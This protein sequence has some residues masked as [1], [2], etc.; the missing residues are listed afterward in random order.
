M[1]LNVWYDGYK[2]TI[3]ELNA[4][5]TEGLWISLSLESDEEMSQEEKEKRIQEAFNERFNKPD[6]NSWHKHRRHSGLS[7]SQFTEDREMAGM[8]A[9]DVLLGEV[10]DS[11]LFRSGIDEWEE[12]QEYEEL[13][14]WVRKVLV[15][16]PEWAEAFI[17]ICM[18]GETTR[19]Y[20]KRV[21]T[22]GQNISMKLGRAKKK[23]RE[24]WP[25]RYTQNP[26]VPNKKENDIR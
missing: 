21:G 7:K 20:A 6:Y 10:R 18:D 4:E 13:C 17:A 26:S 3:I 19:A 9:A 15:K 23:L 14:S 1:K 5:E 16:H 11:A 12:Q 2:E 25:N 22:S 24:A 8:D